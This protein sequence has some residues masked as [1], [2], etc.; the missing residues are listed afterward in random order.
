MAVVTRAMVPRLMSDKGNLKM[1][2]KLTKAK[3]GEMLEHGE[4]HGKPLTEKQKGFFGLIRGGG[5]PTRLKKH[6]PSPPYGQKGRFP[7]GGAIGIP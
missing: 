1:K 6:N 4:V 5:K 2:R 3:A 7:A